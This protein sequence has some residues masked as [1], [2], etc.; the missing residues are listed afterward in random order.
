MTLTE[1]NTNTLSGVRHDNATT[2]PITDSTIIT[3]DE[4]VEL[5][6]GKLITSIT[7]LS[8]SLVGIA[9]TTKTMGVVAT[10][11]SLEYVGVV[12]EG[13]V[14]V[15][16]LVEGSG[17]TY[18]TALVVGDIVSFHYDATAGY[19]Q[20]I[21]NSTS[22]PIGR[23]VGGGVASSGTTADQWDYVLVQLDFERGGSSRI[24]DGAVTTAKLADSAVTSTK[25]GTNVPGSINSTKQHLDVG[26]FTLNATLGTATLDWS[27]T[28]SATTGVKVFMQALT[29]TGSIPIAGAMTDTSFAATGGNAQTGSWFA[30]IPDSSK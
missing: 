10:T 15:K 6:S 23:I 17:G 1:L 29:V 5:S 11:G 20:F 4:F 2:L 9:Q 22:S 3:K 14:K 12:T 24:V 18:K 26:T 16:G 19:G 27:T 21:V 25:T 8:S 30:W 7:T 28:L 13:I